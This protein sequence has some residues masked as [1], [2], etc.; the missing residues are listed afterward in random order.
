ML[1]ASLAWVSRFR[2]NP[3]FAGPA[4]PASGKS[5]HLFPGT[6]GATWGTDPPFVEHG[7]L[8]GAAEPSF[9]SQPPDVARPINFAFRLCL[10][11]GVGSGPR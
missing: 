7:L 1:Q 6:V 4:T 11:L 3:R 5:E 8:R 9:K 2:A 10:A